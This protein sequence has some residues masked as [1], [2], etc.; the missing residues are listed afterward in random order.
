MA[1]MPGMPAMGPMPGMLTADQMTK[2]DAARGPDF[3]KLFLVYM[4]QHHTGALSMVN[5]L[6]ESE[7]AGQDG[8]IFK[9]ASDV[10]ADQ[11]AE[12]GR[13]EIMLTAPAAPG[14]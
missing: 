4:I 8:D 6:F 2:L 5:D 13:M 12:I 3:D 1:A 9:F 11:T 10:G 14:Q 7:G